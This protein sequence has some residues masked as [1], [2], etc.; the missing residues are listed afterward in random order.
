MQG[1]LC[2]DIMYLPGVGPNRKKMLNEE[3]GIKTF[4]DLLGYFPYK[5]VDRSRLYSISELNSE[6]PYVQV[7]GRILSYETFENGPRRERVVAHFSDGFGVMDLTW[8]SGGKGIKQRYQA[9]KD[10]VVFGKP[11][12]FN[13]RYNIIHPDIDPASELQLDDMGMQPYYNTTEKM[14]KMGLTSHAIEKLTRNLLEKLKEEIAETL[15]P[16]PG[17]THHSLSPQ[18]PGTGTGT[19]ETEV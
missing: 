6:M 11:T 13:G 9:G 18:P 15:F 17:T 10:Y 19:C 2:Q 4:G 7:R 5:Y 3:L 8:F 14:K 16:R 12:V 1:I